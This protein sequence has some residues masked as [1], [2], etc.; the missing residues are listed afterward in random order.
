[1]MVLRQAVPVSALRLGGRRS[2]CHPVPAVVP[3]TVHQHLSSASSP[4]SQ[5]LSVAIVGSG[6]SGMYTAKYLT[7]ALAKH[8]NDQYAAHATIDVIE[9]LPTPFGLVRSGVAPDHPEVKNVE[10]DF[11]A[12]FD[13]DGSCLTFRGNVEV[14]RDVSLPELRSFY[15]VVVLAYGCESDRKLGSP[16][17]DLVGVLSAREF[18]GWY[19]GH[20]DY[21]HLTDVLSQ[22]ILTDPS[23]ADVAVVG[24]GNVALDCARVLAK[25]TKGLSSTD[26]ASHALEVLRDGVRKVTVVGRRGHIQGAF[27]IK[28]I[29][30]LTKLKKEG[31]DVSFRV[32]QE[33]LDM[34]MTEASL[35][36]LEGAK[37]RPKKRI[38]KLLREAAVASSLVI[39]N[40]NE[41]EVS[42]RMLMNPVEFLPSETDP[43]L[44]GS[45]VCERTRLEGKAGEQSA[46]GTGEFETIPANLALLSIGYKGLC[47]PGLEGSFDERRGTIDN[48]HGKVSGED[49]GGLYCSGWIKRGPSG[50]IGTNI[51]DAKDTV[52]AILTDLEARALTKDND[53]GSPRGRLGLDT[54]L[55][56]RN[57]RVVNWESYAEID[58]AEKEA[59]RL[60]AEGQPR[61]KITSIQDMLSVIS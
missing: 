6:P 49:S 54:L 58:A 22:R 14:G 42:L 15:D 32:S 23:T 21:V 29:R 20:P 13:E 35:A 60:R 3:K 51:Q 45:V 38:D 59:S 9:K 36:E 34:G 31:L 47:L 26:I 30:E 37:A 50:I 46:V 1:M 52:A 11:R 57:T 39:A 10:N 28:E 40:A 55:K 16:G 33:E 18:V 4:P 53:T 43:A 24:H 5:S 25:G 41:R 44:I 48:D 2:V 12:L 61:E 17:E 7:S 19:N 8:P 56:E 27:T